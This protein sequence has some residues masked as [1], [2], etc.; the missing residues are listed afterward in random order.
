MIQLDIVM[1]ATAIIPNKDVVASAHTSTNKVNDVI[2]ATVAVTPPVAELGGRARDRR[3]HDDASS[4]A[5]N[6]TAKIPA[7][8]IPAVNS[9]HGRVVAEADMTR[10]LR[11]YG[12]STQD[13]NTTTT[14]SSHD[15]ESVS[16]VA[17]G[18]AHIARL[19]YTNA[20]CMLTSSLPSSSPDLLPLPGSTSSSP[21]P[22]RNIMTITWLTPTTNHVYALSDC[23]TLHKFHEIPDVHGTGSLHVFNACYT[24]FG[25][26]N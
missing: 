1:A 14:S 13:N 11:R 3:R 25:S 23:I 15:N 19:L 5:R 21:L 12:P 8:I 4:A 7:A 9:N 10:Y 16:I 24:L 26:H 2:N 22:R 17:V 6:K 18:R 20:V